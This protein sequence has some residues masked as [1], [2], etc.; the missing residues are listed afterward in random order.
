MS[1]TYIVKL[2]YQLCTHARLRASTCPHDLSTY[3]RTVAHTYSSIRHYLTISPT[4]PFSVR[5]RI[6]PVGPSRSRWERPTG[7]HPR[8][9][10]HSWIPLSACLFCCQVPQRV[11]L[12]ERERVN[13]DVQ[14]LH[15]ERE[16][17]RERERDSEVAKR[18]SHRVPSPALQ[19]QQFTN[20]RFTNTVVSLILVPLYLPLGAA[21]RRSSPVPLVPAVTA[22]TT[23]VT[24]RLEVAAYTI[25]LTLKYMVF[26]LRLCGVR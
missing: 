16:R 19:H 22:M 5:A 9:V 23:P 3:S 24:E 6:L 7:H 12:W 20:E 2:F 1:C 17:E 21:S 4:R 11:K 10:P 18:T 15:K 25:A 13:I 14:N 26:N 8:H